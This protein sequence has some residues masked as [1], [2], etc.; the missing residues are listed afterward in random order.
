MASAIKRLV[1][2]VRSLGYQ[3]VW[4]V[5]TSGGGLPSIRF[6]AQVAAEGL[7]LMGPVL[8]GSYICDSPAERVLDSLRAEY[9]GQEAHVW[10]KHIVFS[11]DNAKDSRSATTLSGILDAQL[12]PVPGSQH[13]ILLPLLISGRLEW[14]LENNILPELLHGDR[15]Q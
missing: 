8:P 11:I 12:R 9:T 7:T 2:Y 4:V 3:K 10:Q 5:G 14:E 6:A 15:V 13:G 1:S